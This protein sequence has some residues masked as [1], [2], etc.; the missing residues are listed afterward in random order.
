MSPYHSLAFSILTGLCLLFCGAVGQAQEFE[1]GARSIV[2]AHNC[3]P[4]SGLW[5]NRMTQALECPFPVAI[6]LDLLWHADGNEGQGEVVVGHNPPGEEGNPSLQHWFF[7][8]V[9]P[10]VEEALARG[11]DDDWPLITLNI[12]DIRGGDDALFQGVFDIIEEHSHWFCSAEKGADSEK[13]ASL[14]VAPVLVL[15]GGGAQEKKHFYDAVP[16]GGALRIFGSGSLSEKADNFR[17]WINFPWKAVEPEGQPDAGAWSDAD[18]A[19]LKELVDTAHEQGY[20]I[21][22]YTLNGHHPVATVRNGWAPL[23]N[24]GSI[25]AVRERWS[26]ARDAGVD[27]IATDQCF[28]ASVWLNP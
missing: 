27:F 13:A 24:F 16:E 5:R 1:P 2:E 20:W 15:S 8:P 7:D 11:V 19:R 25:D 9:R 3:Y 4:Y 17:R 21:R 14:Q 22:F 26:A 6:E 23:Y 28:E 10:L 12:N 18:A